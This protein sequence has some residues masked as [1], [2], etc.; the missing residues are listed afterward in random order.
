MIRLFK[1]TLLCLC[2]SGSV[3]AGFSQTSVT[4]DFDS[5]EPFTDFESYSEDGF[6]ITPNVG[7]VRI[8]D[9]FPPFGNAAQPSF[10]FGQGMDSGFTFTSALPSPFGLSSIDLLE[11]SDYPD[12]FAVT[13]IGT[14]SDFSL[15]TQTLI[16][17][18]IPGAETFTV[19]GFSGLQSLRIAEDSANGFYIDIVQIDNVRFTVVPEP[20]CCGLLV[21]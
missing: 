1:L 9:A 15:V 21:A 14:R 20:S 18:G 6:T 3:L 11:A 17:D 5:V 10:G 13:L 2:A 12:K 7:R 4:I 19:S 8:N 16:L